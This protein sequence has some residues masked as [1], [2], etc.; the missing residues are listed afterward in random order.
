[1]R[2]LLV[3]ARA[4]AVRGKNKASHL[5]GKRHSPETNVVRCLLFFIFRIHPQSKKSPIELD[6]K[7]SAN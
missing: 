1:M 7:P 3:R 6:G 5:V 4:E 2:P